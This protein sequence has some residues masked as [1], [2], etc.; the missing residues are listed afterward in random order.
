M[1]PFMAFFFPYQ[2]AF[3]NCSSICF[4][5]GDVGDY[6]PTKYSNVI[7]FTGTYTNGKNPK[8]ALKIRVTFNHDKTLQNVYYNRNSGAVTILL[9]IVGERGGLT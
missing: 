5:T 3:C 7:T 9:Q 2:F 8:Y 6:N 4:S 1:I